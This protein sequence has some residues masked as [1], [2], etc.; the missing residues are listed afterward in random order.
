MS[1]PRMSIVLLGFLIASAS[2]PCFAQEEAPKVSLDVQDSTVGAVAQMIAMAGGFEVSVAPGVAD[3]PVQRFSVDGV[4]ARQ[5]LQMLCVTAGVELKEA[6][7]AYEIVRKGAAPPEPAPAEEAE[8][9]ELPTEPLVIDDMEG[10]VA[11]RW[12][13]NWDKNMVDLVADNE[14]VKQGETSGKWDPDTAAKYIFHQRTP[15]DWTGYDSVALWI[16]SEQAT[17]AVMA[18]LADSDNPD[19]EQRDYYRCLIKIDW[20]GWRELRL[21]ER[22]FQRAYEPVGFHKIDMMRLA[23]EGWPTWVEY[24]PG[25]VLRIDDIRAMPAEPPGDELVIF[26][27]DTDWGCLAYGSGAIGCVKEPT[28]TGGRVAEWVSTIAQTSL[29]NTAVP[30]DWSAYEYV[31]MW[32]YCK[33]PTDGEILFWVESENPATEGH[34]RYQVKIPLDWQGWKLLS[35]AYSDL[36]SVRAPLGWDQINI[37]RF[38]SAGYVKQGE[39]TTL[40]FDDMWLSKQPPGELGEEE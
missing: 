16:H 39:G 5:A 24:V 17:D 26:H 8:P 32:V 36:M 13:D 29:Y 9:R 33:E 31:N 12:H 10:D 19:T 27:P 30:R 25:T 11:K 28:K 2:V 22:S 21:Y 35:Y 23:F 18:L 6:D 37:L 15:H 7:G 14:V 20:E 40:Y 34:D 3:K 1:G 38:Y 4:S